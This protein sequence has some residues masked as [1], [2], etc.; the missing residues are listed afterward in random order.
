MS[1]DPGIIERQ[2]KTESRFDGEYA[3]LVKALHD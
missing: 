2:P 1:W 3:E